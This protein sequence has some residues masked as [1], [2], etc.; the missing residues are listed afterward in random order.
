METCIRCGA[1][2]LKYLIEEPHYTRS[3]RWWRVPLTGAD[4]P[5]IGMDNIRQYIEKQPWC[6]VGG[7]FFNSTGARKIAPIAIS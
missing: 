7:S 3:G 1:R 6:F 5:E 2:W 4:L